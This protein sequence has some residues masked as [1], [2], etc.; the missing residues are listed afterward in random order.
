MAIQDICLRPPYSGLGQ[1]CGKALHRMAR[2]AL[3]MIGAL[4]VFGCARNEP[5]IV[6][7]GPE[8]VTVDAGEHVALWGDVSDP[9]G[10]VHAQHWEQVSGQPI[11]L[12]NADRLELEF[13][14]PVVD[15][16]T[17]FR[18]RLTATDNSGETSSG[19]VT[20]DV[21]PYGNLRVSLAGTVRGHAS[22]AVIEGASVT[23]S[24]NN[25]GKPRMMSN[26]ETDKGGGFLVDLRTM[27]GRLLVNVEAEGYAP[28]SAIV[29]LEDGQ[30]T[31]A[32]N[33]DL[34]PIQIIQEFAATQGA[35]VG[36]D[37]QPV[38]SLPPNVLVTEDG[39]NYSRQA[40]VAVTVLDPSRNP[41]VM[42]GDFLSWESLSQAPVPIES[43]G[44]INIVLESGNG[45]PLQL[46]PK[47]RARVSIPLAAGHSSSE[48]PPT[49][50]LYFWSEDL[51][52]WIEE[53]E[54]R[55]EQ[56]SEGM[57]AYTG[58]VGHFTTW[59][60][61][62][63]Y[64]SVSVSGCV[65]D[66]DGKPVGLA[67]VTAQG[68]DYTGT[69]SATSH[70]DGLFKIDV[71]PNSE[72]QL[73]AA[74]GD[75]S[76]EAV[77]VQ[78]GDGATELKECLVVLGER[79]LSD[80]PIQIEGESGT[81]QVC[82]RDHECEDGDA[83]SVDVAG[84]NMFN[85]EITNEWAC[86]EFDVESDRN[87]VIEM[88]ALNGTGYKG[89]C[90]Y[91]DANT[92]EI[93]VSGQ[94]VE[95][96]M[97][98]H[99]EGAGSKARIVVERWNNPIVITSHRD[100]QRVAD[101]NIEIEGEANP[102]LGNDIIVRYNG[103]EENT[104]LSNGQFTASVTLRAGPNQIEVCQANEH[105]TA[106]IVVADIENLGLMVHVS[107]SASSIGMLRLHVETPL[108]V[109]CSIDNDYEPN[110][111]E[112][113]RPFGWNAE[114]IRIPA[115]GSPGKY[116]FWIVNHRNENRRD[117]EA[118]FSAELVILD[119]GIA[120]GEPIEIDVPSGTTGE[121]VFTHEINYRPQ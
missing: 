44:A 119:D 65:A 13:I 29:A 102:D 5:P 53:G 12:R 68:I 108:G 27:P 97:W 58:T 7:V 100:N 85:G 52:Y 80:F 36:I 104:T 75:F 111:C 64:E 51:G 60:A 84:R 15:T 106:I 37:G 101:R 63:A 55:L 31:R 73:V 76:S 57:W 50:P 20:V 82:V 79:G 103:F 96:Q 78:S 25:A 87:Y 11:S 21:R 91:A 70:S 89:A 93:R 8:Q 67:E 77:T 32:V 98:R 4:L 113:E 109:R 110:A 116:R 47:S 74:S 112:H 38:L 62:V 66:K 81:V 72:L 83:I 22:H 16:L 45:D 14:A 17:T 120:V 43:Y 71:R 1:P 69:S 115:T 42:P 18:F 41:T 10:S 49:M 99:R 118:A 94:N 48:A 95:T 88:T 105:C 34:V 121:T 92:G 107:V 28:Q 86:N 33:L 24:Q 9:D 46:N 90:S 2:V 61:D 114:N 56:V 3:A 39:E 35:E 117:P 59:N 6:V 54:A 40:T 19:D 26:A 30:E 23:V